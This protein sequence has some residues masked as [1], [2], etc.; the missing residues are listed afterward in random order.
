MSIE[1]G[2]WNYH[3]GTK[4]TTGVDKD[5]AKNKQTNNKEEEKKNTNVAS[6]VRFFQLREKGA[7]NRTVQA[8]TVLIYYQV[9][10]PQNIA[11]YL[12]L[13]IIVV[14]SSFC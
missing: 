11:F 4:E 7:I 8:F 3:P 9:H 10:G 12:P 13:D 6:Q 1:Q 5:V 14:W 2:R